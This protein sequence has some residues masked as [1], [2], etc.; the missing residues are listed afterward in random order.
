MRIGKIKDWEVE[1]TLTQKDCK[2]I[3]D[4]LQ[5]HLQ[6]VRIK[7]FNSTGRPNLDELLTFLLNSQ[8]K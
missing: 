2:D 5:T 7:D 8:D 3:G 1:L 6:Y 4:I